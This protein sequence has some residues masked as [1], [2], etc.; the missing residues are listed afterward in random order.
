MLSWSR[1]EWI[2]V[3]ILMIFGSLMKKTEGRECTSYICERL[4]G[5]MMG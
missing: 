1:K 2:I 4:I 5:I 3:K